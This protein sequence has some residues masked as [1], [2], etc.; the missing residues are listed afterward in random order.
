MLGLFLHDQRFFFFVQSHVFNQDVRRS[1]VVAVHAVKV[2]ML[3]KV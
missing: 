2:Y 1:E 3:M